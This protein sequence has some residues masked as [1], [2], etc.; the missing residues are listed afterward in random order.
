MKPVIFLGA[1]GNVSNMVEIAEYCNRKVIGIID[2]DYY[3]NTS[4]LDGID[5]IGSESDFD[6]VAQHAHFDFFIGTNPIPGNPRD[7]QKRHR[8]IALVKQ[9]NLNCANFIDPTARVSP[10]VVLGKGIYV[11]FCSNLASH[12]TI[13]DHVQIHGHVGVGHHCIID[14]NSV[15]QRKVILGGWIHLQK[16]A[17]LGISVNVVAPTGGTKGYLTIGANSV[18][19]PG[20]TVMRPVADNEVV[21]PGSRKIYRDQS[22]IT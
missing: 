15:L 3:G 13:G 2:K 22:L 5:I 17:Y 1:N 16:N 21:L 8:L 7:I 9:Q 4:S 20:C 12:V 10:S 18:I 6:F 11:G 14:E 19:S